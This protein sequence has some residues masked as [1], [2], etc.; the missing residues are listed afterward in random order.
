VLGGDIANYTMSSAAYIECR[1]CGNQ[2]DMNLT[3]FPCR[4]CGGFLDPVYDLETL[5]I[6][7]RTLESRCGSMWKYRELLP[8]QDE[9]A[10]VSLG[11]GGTPLIEC[12]DLADE[13][14]I[15][16]LVVKDEGQN[17]TSTFKDRGAS[18]TMSGLRERGQEEA[19]IISVGNAGHA[20]AAYAARAG[21]TVHIYL[22]QERGGLAS[23]MMQGHDA[24]LYLGEDYVTTEEQMNADAAE[25]GWVPLAPFNAPFR[26]EG[27]KTMGL[28]LFERFDW[29]PPD[30]VVYPTGGGVGVV[31]IWKAFQHY[32][33]LGWLDDD[34]VP[35]VHV[36]QTEDCAPIARAIKEDADEHTRWENP[37]SIAR[38]VMNPDP[39]ASSWIIDCVRESGGTGIVVQDENAIDA[40]LE[41][42]SREGVEMGI[43]SSVALAGAFKLAERGVV[44]EDETV[45]V[46]NTGA[47]GKSHAELARFQPRLD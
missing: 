34:T 13:H 31:G 5:D 16:S 1:S 9:S 30:H 23:T 19:Y 22:T 4:E 28:E 17:P 12:P 32:Y 46:I 20:A 18:V 3:E 44:S 42:M 25:H 24:E 40:A 45:A 27:K 6:D 35:S 38:G 39:G 10:V 8:I 14:G 29:S 43:S 11:E 7:R 33:D 26:H 36:A 2:Y 37:E 21:I 15:G 47:A 41:V